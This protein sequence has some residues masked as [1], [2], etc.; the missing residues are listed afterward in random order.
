MLNV[1]KFGL[2]RSDIRLH[3]W[4][5]II[6]FTSSILLMGSALFLGT[7]GIDDELLAL[8]PF[9]KGTP[10]GLWATELVTYLLP[11]QNGISFIPIFLGCMLYSVAISLLI[12]LWNLKERNLALLSAAIMGSFP[13]FASMM[14][15]DVVQIAYPLGF[16]FIILS[17]FPVFKSPFNLWSF[18]L[19]TLSFVVAFALYQ[20]VAPMVMTTFISAAG[21][22]FIIAADKNKEFNIFWSRY[23]PRFSLLL[24]I[25]S[26]FYLISVKISK[27]LTSYQ[28]IESTYS[29]TMKLQFLDPS[30]YRAFED[31]V[32]L[33]LR[34]SNDLPQLSSTIFL[35][36]II[37]ISIAIFKIPHFAILKKVIVFALLL[38]SVFVLPFWLNFIQENQL[39]PRSSVGI[40]FLYGLFFI[41]ITYNA[42]KYFKSISYFI[43]FIW[44][45]QFIF[46]GNE[47]YYAQHLMSK[48][49]QITI[50]RILARIDALAS[51]KQLTYPTPVMF[52]GGY[53]PG[54]NKFARFNT[55]GSSAF[56]WGQENQ[57]RQDYLF[58][59]YGVDGLNFVYNQKLKNEI[60]QYIVSEKVPKWPAPP[61]TFIYQ[62]KIVVVNFGGFPD[63]DWEKQS[64]IPNLSEA[65]NKILFNSLTDKKLGAPD[66]DIALSSYNSI[67][68][69]PGNTPTEAEFSIAGKFEKVE[70]VTFIGLLPPEA[71]LDT[72][73]GTVG[74]EL[75]TDG[76]LIARQ[77]VNRNTIQTLNLDLSQVKKFRVKVDCADSN[78]GY[79]WLNIGIKD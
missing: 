54:G 2:N 44:F 10:R 7:L 56:S 55:L 12:F 31:N 6:C 50:N 46:L 30:F 69:H 51:E 26:I 17:V 3:K 58:N 43:G 75:F 73:G 19:G 37:P 59:V 79:D 32:W 70:L 29:V 36:A 4:I 49:E 9:Y 11:G 45:I 38:F 15:F 23:F 25:G 42:S 74:I 16:I 8:Q 47:M 13:Y 57:S 27:L 48:S 28:E 71:L 39:T 14:T 34:S 76:D 77:Y 18:F 22:R 67:F 24:V 61:S 52:L 65:K 60:S 41:A 68:L 5:F 53:V 20:G 63:L 64:I 78:C 40:A 72:L 66:I 21:V 33:I 62:D 1:Q 35:I